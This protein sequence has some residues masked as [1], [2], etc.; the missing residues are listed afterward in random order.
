M[1]TN[2]TQQVKRCK[3][4]II[5]VGHERYEVGTEWLPHFFTAN[6]HAE[7]I[8]TD[9]IC[10]DCSA[11]WRNELRDRSVADRE[12]HILEVPG[13][14][15][16]PATSF[17][18]R[19][20]LGQVAPSADGSCVAPKVS[21]RP[22][23]SAALHRVLQF[24]SRRRRSSSERRRFY[25]FRRRNGRGYRLGKFLSLSHKEWGL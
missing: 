11:L 24:I 10:S 22:L 2:S 5:K 13:S 8:F 25:F 17:H 18:A 7:I 6:L 9:G 21:R 12:A 23:L 20:G 19:L 16:G 1:S 3:W 15:P 4:C 14:I